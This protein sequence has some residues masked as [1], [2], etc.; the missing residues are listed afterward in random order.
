MFQYYF[1]HLS[2]SLHVPGF[3]TPNDEHTRHENTFLYCLKC[4]KSK[5]QVSEIEK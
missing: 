5:P 2:V 4:V 1:Q 3:L